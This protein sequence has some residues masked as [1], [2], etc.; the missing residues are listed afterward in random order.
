MSFGLTGYADKFTVQPGEK[1]KFMISTDAPSFEVG[2]VRLLQADQNVD[3][4]GYNEE[5][6]DADVNGTYPGRQQ[7][8]FPGSWV[9]ISD[10]K[11]LDLVRGLRFRHGFTPLCLIRKANR[12]SSQSGQT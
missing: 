3:G 8:V 7:E 6:I 10:S 9:Q 2:I 5:K 1:I 12:D 11:T 4:P